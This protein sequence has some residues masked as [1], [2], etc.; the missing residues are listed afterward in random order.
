M[1]TVPSRVIGIDLGARRIGVAL[2]DEPRVIVES[3]AATGE[4]LVF[5]LA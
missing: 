4:V 2:T 5:D 3:G 1:S